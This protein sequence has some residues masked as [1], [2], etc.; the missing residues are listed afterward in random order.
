MGDSPPHSSSNS[1]HLKADTISHKD[2]RAIISSQQAVANAV[3]HRIT[4]VHNMEVNPTRV[5]AVERTTNREP[6][7]IVEN[8]LVP[9]P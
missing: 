8:E 9:N 1:D 5:V 6:I 7:R 4:D 3:R 2:N